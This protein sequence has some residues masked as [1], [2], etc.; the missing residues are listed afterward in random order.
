VQLSA[1]IKKVALTPSNFNGLKDISMV[2]ENK[3]YKYMYG[4][5]PDYNE[6]KK[7]LEEA[8]TKGYS[9]AYLIAFKNGTKISV[10]DALST[11]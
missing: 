10:Q 1:S 7:K 4:E 5:T 11:N 9:S 3:Y 8:K 2:S 6:A